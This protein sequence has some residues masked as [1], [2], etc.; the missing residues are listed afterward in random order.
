VHKVAQSSR[1]SLN[2]LLCDPQ[3]S[4]TSVK[5]LKCGRFS[6]RFRVEEKVFRFAIIHTSRASRKT[7]CNDLFGWMPSVL[8]LNCIIL[9]QLESSKLGCGKWNLKDRRDAM[10]IALSQQT[11]QS[12][13]TSNCTRKWE[14]NKRKGKTFSSMLKSKDGGGAKCRQTGASCIPPNW[15][16]CFSHDEL[17]CD[18][19]FMQLRSLMLHLFINCDLN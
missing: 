15:S 9:A 13:S 14:K 6:R 18:E 19:I 2:K 10:L 7:Q 1:I 5:S 8:K 12:R 3:S 16:H 17:V 11:T 4:Q